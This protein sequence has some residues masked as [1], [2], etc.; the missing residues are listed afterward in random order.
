MPH[1]SSP[2]IE[3]EDQVDDTTYQ[4][5]DAMHQDQV[6]DATHHHGRIFRSPSPPIDIEENEDTRSSSP[7]AGSKRPH[8]TDDEDNDSTEEDN[9]H[10]SKAPK[11]QKRNARPKAGDYDDLGKE[12]VLAAANRY[13]AL[14]AS[15]GAFPTSSMELKLV[16]KSWKL[17]D[18]EN[19]GNSLALTPSIVSIVSKFLIIIFFLFAE[20][21]CI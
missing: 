10:V 21:L 3:D 16:K 12:L 11:L 7:Q 4:D 5:D 2:A 20:C 18:T 9:V 19:G 17:V 8:T 14:L 6:D 1:S 15:Q 13:R